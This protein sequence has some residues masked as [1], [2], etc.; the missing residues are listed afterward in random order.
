MNIFEFNF[1]GLVGPT[2][3]YSGLSVGNLASGSHKNQMSNPK[4]AA[5][6]GLLKMK[7]LH[8]LGFKQGVL[9]PQERPNIAVLKSLGFEG[10]DESII[11]Q[12]FKSSPEIL[13]C[14]TSA[15]SMWTAN[16]ATVSPS[17]DTADNKVH[18]TPANLNSMF[19][20]SIEH[21]TTSKVLKKIFA[22]NNYFVHHNALPSVSHFGDEGAANHTRFCNNYGDKGIEFFVF[23][24]YA[25]D[26]S[27]LRPK[28]FVARQTYEASQAIARKHKLDPRFVVY[29]QQNP[30]V[31]DQGV[32]HNDVI[33]VGNRNI[34]FCHEEAFL[35]KAEIY[36]SLTQKI[37]LGIIEVPT[38]K[39]SVKDCVQSYLF[40]SQIITQN[41]INTIV[42]P[43]E[44]RNNPRVWSF[45]NDI[46]SD[47]HSG[48]DEI[49]VFNLTESMSNG[50]GPACL[51][52]RVVLNKKEQEAMNSE[53]IL[54]DEKYNVLVNWVNKYYRDQLVPNDL[55]DPLLLNESR[56]AL[57]ELT[58]ILCL[59]SIYD[60]QQI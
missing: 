35:N 1:D 24:Q 38:N 44:S 26:K 3:N 60:F 28:S 12:A 16:A 39:V 46:Q 5:L 48:I 13:S 18:F 7:A 57:D 23:G 49:K 41:K 19:H 25:F 37:D 36:K 55:K 40:N 32:F 50:G 27:K 17:S 29:A 59:G 8:D 2:H 54:N 9:P 4:E 31:I 42:L 47:P 34:L 10:T 53:V 45:I 51:R 58:K 43:E 11:T 20:R 22:D 30:N 33:S 6:Q 21:K 14:V 52:L 56:A 15:S